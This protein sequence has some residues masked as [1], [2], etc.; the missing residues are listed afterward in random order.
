MGYLMAVRL[1]GDSV[2]WRSSQLMYACSEGRDRYDKS[3]CDVLEEPGLKIGLGPVLGK[4]VDRGW[5]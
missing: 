4:H 2:I 3:M 5:R 1:C